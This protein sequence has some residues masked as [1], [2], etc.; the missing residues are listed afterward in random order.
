MQPSISR[1]LPA[2]SLP[3][4]ARVRI[5]EL[6]MRSARREFDQALAVRANERRDQER[7]AAA[8]AVVREASER[9]QLIRFE[10]M[11]ARTDE[12]RAS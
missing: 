1:K 5:L 8:D 4:T 11:R 10:L 9:M 3:P 6:E 12:R 7:F 2:R